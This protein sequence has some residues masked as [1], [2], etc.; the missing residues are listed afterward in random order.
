[1]PL[2]VTR[3]ASSHEQIRSA[4]RD[5]SGGRPG[6]I[7]TQHPYAPG[8]WP[9]ALAAVVA[10]RAS[11][12]TG[13]WWLVSRHSDQDIRVSARS[14]STRAAAQGQAT[15]INARCSW[16]RTYL[17][18]VHAAEITVWAGPDAILHE[19]ARRP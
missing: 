11:L 6:W 4:L 2:T 18:S 12:V 15:R 13:Q 1:M 19:R 16:Q 14:Y 8:D 7:D 3:A 17:V 9:A 5:R 10:T